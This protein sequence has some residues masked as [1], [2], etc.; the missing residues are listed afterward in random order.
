MPH[1]LPRSEKRRG[2]GAQRLLP[3]CHGRIHGRVREI[4][5]HPVEERRDLVLQGKHVFGAAGAAGGEFAHEQDQHIAGA[6]LL[7]RP[8]ALR[9]RARVPGHK[10]SEGAQPLPDGVVG[11]EFFEQ[12]ALVGA[13]AL[14]GELADDLLRR[15]C[16]VAPG[17]A[18]GELDIG[19]VLDVLLHVVREPHDGDRGRLRLGD[20]RGRSAARLEHVR[21]QQQDLGHR[22]Q[23]PRADAGRDG[24]MAH[25]APDELGGQLGGEGLA[26]VELPA[27]DYERIGLDA[28]RDLRN[29]GKELDGRTVPGVKLRADARVSRRVEPPALDVAEETPDK[30]ALRPKLGLRRHTFPCGLSPAGTLALAAVVGCHDIDAIRTLRRSRRARRG[31]SAAK[32]ALPYET[33]MPRPAPSVTSPGASRR[34]R[35]SSAARAAWEPPLPRRRRL[36]RAGNPALPTGGP[37]VQRI[38]KAA[39]LDTGSRI[40]GT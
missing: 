17:Q 9:R 16:G 24:D 3:G 1:G 34:T 28:Q 22:G 40:L 19:G 37:G 13:D 18:A 30:L 39:D 35:R 31:G 25:E 29:P 4:G 20:D 36:P 32:I 12:P 6:H 33:I 7:R 8:L 23:I 14:L 2:Q 26:V 38:A 15:A 10:H 5:L 27:H 11:H 21:V